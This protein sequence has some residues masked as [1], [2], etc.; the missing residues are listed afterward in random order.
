MYHAS[1][2]MPVVADDVIERLERALTAMVRQLQLPRAVQR[3]TAGAAPGLERA[4]FVALRRIHDGG[5]MRL[6]ELAQQLD[7]DPSTVSRQVRQL[8]GAGLVARQG[9][10]GDG[11]ANVVA[12]TPAGRRALRA[13]AA[14]R[15]KFLAEVTAGWSDDDRAALARLVDRFAGDLA[16][17]LATPGTLVSPKRE[18]QGEPRP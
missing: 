18:P 14:G 11:R 1:M 5:G 6:S 3:V 13:L 17:H 16:A 15:R 7:L 12:L 4:A 2:S 9:D 10:P 8:E